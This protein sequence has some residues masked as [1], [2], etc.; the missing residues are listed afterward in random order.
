MQVEG[1][2]KRQCGDFVLD[3][4][5]QHNAQPFSGT[6][7]LENSYIT[8]CRYSRTHPDHVGHC[9]CHDYGSR[10][11]IGFVNLLSAFL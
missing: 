1:E 9:Q 10:C 11:I 4:L 8:N 5:L 2:K 3:P 7:S 6:F